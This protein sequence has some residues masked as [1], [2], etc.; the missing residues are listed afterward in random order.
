[1]ASQVAPS[2]RFRGLGLRVS[3]LLLALGIAI[4]V[5]S[6]VVDVVSRATSPEA[7]VRRYFSALQ[8]GDID[9]AL[10]CLA[11]DIR[12]RERAFVVNGADNEYRVVGVAVHVPSV[13]DRLRGASARPSDVTIFL[14][15][16]PAVDGPEWQ[17]AP[18]V[19]L[20]ELNGRWYLGR[21]PLDSG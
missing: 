6:A 5:G 19:P 21:A 4:L 20:V 7:T 16:I 13:L 17:A 9:G 15:I 10:E 12:A 18:R 14:D 3:F 11:P 2:S 8:R 1:M